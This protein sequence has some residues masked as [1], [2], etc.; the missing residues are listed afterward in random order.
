MYN[1]SSSDGDLVPIQ[2]CNVGSIAFLGILGRGEHFL[3]LYR[4]LC[5]VCSS[6]E[7]VCVLLFFA[8][9]LSLFDR[10][11]G[12]RRLARG[13]CPNL[14]WSATIVESESTAVG[15]S[16]ENTVFATSKT[17]LAGTPCGKSPQ[18]PPP[19]PSSSFAT[20]RSAFFNQT[21]VSLPV[22]V[23]G[24]FFCKSSIEEK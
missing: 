18:L 22:I 6:R 24:S 23:S 20:M 21:S 9:L 1:N 5:C 10:G 4:P 8:L 3:F 15:D 2:P 19:I 11:E 16:V 13:D 14:P 7:G 17:I 12:M